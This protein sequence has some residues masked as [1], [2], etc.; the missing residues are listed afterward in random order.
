MEYGWVERLRGIDTWPVASAS[1]TF[2]WQLS[3]GGRGGA[4][5]KVEFTYR[6]GLE[7]YSGT[8]KVSS[9]SS[10]YELNVGDDFE[11][12]YD[13]RKP[14]RYFC[15]EARSLF[16]TVRTVVL[17]FLVAFVAIIIVINIFH[18]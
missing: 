15:E 17:L 11:I 10:V 9:Y 13:P 16:S 7:I 4:W 3:E 8:L 2:V 14:S 6:A 1:V 5:R 12:Q 18:L